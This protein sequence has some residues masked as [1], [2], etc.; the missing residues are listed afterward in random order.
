MNIPDKNRTLYILEDDLKPE[1]IGDLW[2][3]TVV[4][5]LKKYLLLSQLS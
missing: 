1:L 2:L 3:T 5:L 4:A